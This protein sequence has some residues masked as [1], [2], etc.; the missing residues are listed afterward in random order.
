M[1]ARLGGPH[2]VGGVA[3]EGAVRVPAP[4]QA[5]KALLARLPDSALR[6][7]V[8]AVLQFPRESH[9]RCYIPYV[10]LPKLFHMS[11]VFITLIMYKVLK[12]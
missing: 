10:I 6:Q 1:L 8:I 12:F 9:L 4:A 11:E 3:A 2:G 7:A 5:E